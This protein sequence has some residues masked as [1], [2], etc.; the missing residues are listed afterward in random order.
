[1]EEAR[2]AHSPE[3]TPM[4]WPSGSWKRPMMRLSMTLSGPIIR[5]PPSFS[6]EASAAST[7]GTST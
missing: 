5:V 1:M 7:S 4:V 2:H 6:A 3:S